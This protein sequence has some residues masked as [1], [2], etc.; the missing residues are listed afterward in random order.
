MWWVWSDLRNVIRGIFRLITLSY[1]LILQHMKWTLLFCTHTNS[2]YIRLKPLEILVSLLYSPFLLC[3]YR[4]GSVY[5]GT[6]PLALFP[7]WRVD[8]Y[9]SKWLQPQPFGA[10]NLD[11][12]A[13]VILLLNVV[14]PAIERQSLNMSFIFS[15]I[16]SNYCCLSVHG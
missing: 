8:A 9:W 2:D 11:T 1:R 7:T 12:T 13:S 6:H 14:W 10:D 15:R 5:P 4:L 3:V 16:E